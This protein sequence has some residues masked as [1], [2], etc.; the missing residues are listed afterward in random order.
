MSYQDNF[1]DSLLNSIYHEENGKIA[2]QQFQKALQY[3][4]LLG[5]DLV[6]FIDNFDS[7]EESLSVIESLKCNVIITS[8]NKNPDTFEEMKKDTVIQSMT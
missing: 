6:L 4:N 5:K 3:I 2:E 1:R 7:R 8:R